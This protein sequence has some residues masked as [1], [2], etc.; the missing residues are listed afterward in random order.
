VAEEAADLAGVL[1]GEA[2]GLLFADLGDGLAGGADA[3]GAAHG[4]EF[5]VAAERVA[6]AEVVADHTAEESLEGGAEAAAERGAWDVG[7]AGPVAG[8]RQVARLD[9]AAAGATADV[10]SALRYEAGAER[11]PLVERGVRLDGGHGGHGWSPLLWYR[12]KV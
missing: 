1:P 5:L 11:N 12:A 7:P 2:V 9:A 8:D 6:D 4:G 10:E 3:L